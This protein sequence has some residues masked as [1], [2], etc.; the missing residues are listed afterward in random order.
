[1]VRAQANRIVKGSTTE[2]ATAL[3]Q[4][5]IPVFGGKYIMVVGG[6]MQDTTGTNIGLPNKDNGIRF[7]NYVT[8]SL[9]P[10][11]RFQQYGNGISLSVARDYVAVAGA[12]DHYLVI[13]GFTDFDPANYWNLFRTTASD[14][15]DVID[16]KLASSTTGPSLD[17]PRG[18]ICALTLN[19]NRVLVTGGRGGHTVI[20]SQNIVGTYT[21][22]GSG[23]A[24]TAFAYAK[25]GTLTDARYFHTCTLLQDGSVLVTGGISESGT[26]T[27]DTLSSME[28]FVPRPAAD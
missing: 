12:G 21:D 28:I 14:K 2:D 1:M 9:V 7:Y 11:A 16:L 26:G 4:D 6:N 25:I 24:A 15:S 27:F 3:G 5:C 10:T 22:N 13:G 18:N 8:P 17:V 20:S 19:D 23:V